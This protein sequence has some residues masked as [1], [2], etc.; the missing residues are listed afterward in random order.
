[1]KR[2]NTILLVIAFLAAGNAWAET[3]EVQHDHFWHSC[4]GKL[5]FGEGTVEY[6]TEHNEKELN[7]KYEDIQQL[8]I[9]SGRISILTFKSRGIKFGADQVFNFKVLSGK[10]TDEFRT[11][12]E[13]KLTRPLVSSIVPEQKLVRFSIPARHR[14][15]LSSS[16]GVLEFGDDYLVYRSAGKEASRVWRYDELLSIG[17]T[18]PF[19]LRIGALQK[20]GGEFGEE[21]NYVFDLKRR[22]AAE[23]YDFIWEKINR[24]TIAGK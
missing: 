8:A 9:A 12:M 4:K 11:A 14:L 13:R 21:T 23:E 19:Q 18:G 2:L 1:M 7:W 15:F 16:Q 5:V 3:F 10:L 6:I 20:T 17:S 22:L 24:R